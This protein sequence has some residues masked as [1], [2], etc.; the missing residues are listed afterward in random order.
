MISG[1]TVKVASVPLCHARMLFV[2]A[3]PRETQGMGFD[4]LDR[5]LAFFRGI[6]APRQ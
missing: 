1:V 4:A 2:G 3:Y 5:A 6:G